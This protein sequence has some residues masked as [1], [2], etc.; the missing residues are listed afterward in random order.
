[1]QTIPKEFEKGG[2]MYVGKIVKNYMQG[3]NILASVVVLITILF[4]QYLKKMKSFLIFIY[5]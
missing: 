4:K 5:F 1:M 2:E 3:Q